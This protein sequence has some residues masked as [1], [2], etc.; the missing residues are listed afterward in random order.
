MLLKKFYSLMIILVFLSACSIGKAP[1]GSNTSNGKP[2]S[3]VEPIP[4]N[5]VPSVEPSNTVPVIITITPTYKPTGPPP[6][7][8]SIE[9]C[10]NDGIPSQP[11]NGFG[12]DGSIAFRD[13]GQKIVVGSGTPIAYLE[14]PTPSKQEYELLGF[15]KD[16]NWFAYTSPMT[17]IEQGNLNPTIFLVSSQRELSEKRVE[18][19]EF[20]KNMPDYL[21]LIGIRTQDNQWLNNSLIHLYVMYQATEGTKTIGFYDSVFDIQKRTWEKK[22]YNNISKDRAFENISISPDLTRVLFAEKSGIVLFDEVSHEVLW[23]LNKEL[24]NSRV[25]PIYTWQSD[26]SQAAFA[27]MDEEFQSF[28]IIENNGEA[29][30]KIAPPDIVDKEWYYSIANLQWSPDGNFLAISSLV[31]NPENYSSISML[32]VFDV[33]KESYVYQ[34]PIRDFSTTPMLFWS[35]D[36]RYVVPFLPGELSPLVL[37]DMM[38]SNKVILLKDKVLFGGW[39]YKLFR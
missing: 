25:G 31:T 14:L 13:E 39:S 15:S 5:A 16:G 27:T 36:N 38:G 20:T 19:T 35:P 3:S 10:I 21:K 28:Y 29:I 24:R 7:R 33:S 6:T 2:T 23:R 32:L 34:C 12:I 8:S 4:G 22:F 1:E 17:T 37:Y 18:I 9:L 30:K 11:P 26:S